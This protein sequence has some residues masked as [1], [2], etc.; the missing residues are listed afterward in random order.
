ALAVEATATDVTTPAALVRSTLG[1]ALLRQKKTA[2]AERWF[3]ESL[4]RYRKQARKDAAMAR[5]LRGLAEVRAAQGRVTEA[6]QLRQEAAGLLNPPGLG[7]LYR[8]GP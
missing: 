3:E 1:W 4:A 6:E 5:P 2:E 8:L 7:V